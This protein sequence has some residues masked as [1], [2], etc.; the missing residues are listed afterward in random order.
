MA[1]S[2]R[3]LFADTSVLLLLF[4]VIIGISNVTSGVGPSQVP[5]KLIGEFWNYE[6]KG[7]SSGQTWHQRITETTTNIQTIREGRDDVE[8]YQVDFS[9][10]GT[11]STSDLDYISDISGTNYRT[12][13][14]FALVFHRD[15]EAYRKG[16]VTNTDTYNRTWS[17]PLEDYQFPMSVGQSWTSSSTVTGSDTHFSSTS[18][19]PKT[20]N[21]APINL[22][23]AFSVVGNSTVSVPAGT[24]DCFEIKG[25]YQNGRSFD[26]EFSIDLANTVK[27]TSFDASGQPVETTVLVGWGNGPSIGLSSLLVNEPWLF[28]FLGGIVAGVIIVTVRY[29]RGRHIE[30]TPWK[31]G[32]VVGKTMS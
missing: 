31:I 17:P 25:S 24:F 32:E 18:Q 1:A 14:S 8:V 4:L 26:E 27:E 6:T 23:A 9:G 20:T 29:R 12:V 11:I 5:K 30:A 16:F 19:D 2:R 28:I 10:S 7:S 15:V 22:K 21:I 3:K 13:S